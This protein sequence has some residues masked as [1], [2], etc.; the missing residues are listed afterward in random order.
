MLSVRYAYG[1]LP[2]QN[3][4]RARRFFEEKLGL[5]PYAEV[6]NHLRYEVG[7]AYFVIFPSSG[8]ASGTHDQLGF[9]VEDIKETVAGLRE[10]GVVFEEFEVAGA[11]VEDGIAYFGHLKAAW[12]KDSEGNLLNLAEGLE[13]AA[14]KEESDT[15]AAIARLG[16]GAATD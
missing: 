5:L 13:L 11:S 16:S 3:V 6:N 1:K 2:A 15:I 12:F 14:Q 8:S 10:K 7:G 4:Q 9:M